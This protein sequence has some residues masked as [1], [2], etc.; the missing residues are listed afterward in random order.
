[1]DAIIEN[2]FNA[3]VFERSRTLMWLGTLNLLRLVAAAFILALIVGAVLA[4]FRASSIR[5]LGAVQIWFVDIARAAPPL[6]SLV[7]VFY[8]VP[9]INGFSLGNFEAAVLTFG[10]VQGAYISEIYRGG[11]AAIPR[12]QNEAA[13]ALGMTTFKSARYVIAPQVIRVVTPPLTS[14][15]TQLVRDSSLTFFIGYEEV[16][17]R[18]KQA[19][20]I[21]SNSTPYTMAVVIYATLLI[22]MQLASTY[23][24]RRRN[25]AA[26]PV[27]APPQWVGWRLL[28]RVRGVPLGPAPT[29]GP[30]PTEE[31]AQQREVS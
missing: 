23:L 25:Q 1:M 14:Q 10:L 7:I 19:V 9:P 16:I 8:L 15:F 17:T 3:E 12:G 11:L 31:A 22:S 18:A 27:V 5:A 20:T 26:R 29:A 13:T 28:N 6:V 30:T 2:F 4:S 24:E 21:T